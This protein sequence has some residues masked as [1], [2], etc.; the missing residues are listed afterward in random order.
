[1][2]A[3]G[4]ANVVNAGTIDATGTG[5]HAVGLIG[6]V[7]TGGPSGGSLI[8]GAGGRISGYVAVY[9]DGAMVTNTGSLIGGGGSDGT[10][11]LVIGDGGSVTNAAGGFIGGYFGVNA[12][13]ATNGGATVANAGTIAGTKAAVELASGE[14]NRVIDAPGAVFTGTV[15]GGNTIGAGVSSTL[16]LASGASIGTFTGLGTQFINFAQLV[17]D[18]GASWTLSRGL[19]VTNGIVLTN[20][21]SLGG[22][23]VSISTDGTLTNTSTGTIGVNAGLAITMV[24]GPGTV[25][26][27]GLITST[28]GGFGGNGIALQSGGLISNRS[29][30]VISGYWGIDDT[31]TVSDANAATVF[32]AGTIAGNTAS[33]IGVYLGKGGMVTNQIGARIAAYYGV[34]AH[35]FPT[36]VNAGTISGN[37]G[38]SGLLLLAGGTVTNQSGGVISGAYGIKMPGGSATIENAGSIAGTKDA[39]RFATSVN[40]RLIVDPGA[41]FTG[42]V[43]GGNTLGAAFVSTLELGSA[44]GAGTLNG[45]G[46]QFIDFGQV[47]IDA[48]AVWTLGSSGSVAPDATLTD[49]GTLTNAGVVGLDLDSGGVTLNAGASLTNA[50]GGII[51]A[52]TAIF[53]A[54]G[55]NTVVNAGAIG[56]PETPGGLGIFLASGAIT[57]QSR[58]AIGAY[59]GISVSGSATVVNAGYIDFVASS[60]TGVVVG[61]GLVTNLAGGTI[62][63]GLGVQLTGLGTLEN[64][65]SIYGATDAVR[66]AAGGA[67]RLIDDPGGSFSG[68]VDGGNTIGATAASTLELTSG[69]ST[70]T[71]SG[72]AT[73][74]IDFSQVTVDAGAT[75]TLTGAT[76]VGGATLT[77]AGSVSAN[78]IAVASGGTVS[79]VIGGTITGTPNTGTG[80]FDAITGAAGTATV[81]NDGSIGIATAHGTG[82]GIDLRG[83]G[84]VTNLSNGQ[85]TGNN[86]IYALAAATI[87]NFGTIGDLAGDNFGGVGLGAGGS[88]TNLSGG[89][90][91]AKQAILA[92]GAATVVNNGSIGGASTSGFFGVYVSGGTGSITNQGSGAI[93]G[94]FGIGLIGV[95]GTVENAGNIAGVKDAVL[96]SA[97]FANSLIFDPGAVFTGTVD[98]GNTIGAGAVSTMELTSAPGT[99]TLSGLGAQFVN[100]AQIQIDAGATWTLTGTNTIVAGQTLTNMG[101]L[102]LTGA[103]LISV[104]I[105]INDGV[106]DIDPSSVTLAGIGGSGTIDVGANSTLT[107]SGVVSAG[108]TFVFTGTDAVLNIL[109]SSSFAGTIQDQG[110]TDQVNLACFAAGTRLATMF[111]DVAVEDL[112]TGD[113]VRAMPGNRLVPIVWIGHRHIDC[114]R[115]ADPDSVW[116]VCV[117]AGAFGDAVP[118]RDLRLSPDHAVFVDDV[119]IPIKR[120]INGTTIERVPM[121]EVTYYH[122]EL[123]HHDVLLAEGLPAES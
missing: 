70:G 84:S 103:S 122:I 106:I 3:S 80:S 48:G 22:T 119:L 93:S 18:S 71:L 90:I 19:L 45:L 56:G 112:R 53:G 46:T 97:G 10:G 67:N 15:N 36:V 17:V 13:S 33:G 82:D 40:N 76:I 118:H 49:S 4:P 73:K 61:G 5:N 109:E 110:P 113:R 101:S 65:G 104:G 39:V 63:G 60:G 44:A 87:T 41:A 96:F 32:N 11:V 79:N 1:M 116:P 111:G 105:L 95:A 114:T 57:N 117:R 31:F 85:I 35:Y 42:T 115:H 9:I 7:R 59:I 91:R 66:F 29:Q 16:E 34:L 54:G 2:L 8:N 77:N 108:Q 26:N 30:G 51:A 94:Y 81:V 38:G 12:S 78:G 69:A 68:M 28:S 50:T 74:F 21:G 23:G 62:G 6:P 86:A 120:L 88:V 55:A 14:A 25:V 64:A 107:V 58:G 24:N 83:G 89:V 27:Y 72:L 47:T 52:K 20:A 123:L 100:F 75:W 102:E 43:D 98:G 99:G 37:L 92:S 121:D